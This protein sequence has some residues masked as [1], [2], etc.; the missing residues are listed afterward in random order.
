MASSPQ[1]LQAP[2]MCTLLPACFSCADPHTPCCSEHGL[3]SRCFHFLHLHSGDLIFFLFIVSMVT[4]L[5]CA[6]VPET[7]LR[8]GQLYGCILGIHPII[9]VGVALPS[10]LL[11]ETHL[12]QGVLLCA[13]CCVTGNSLLGMV[14][15]SPVSPSWLRVFICCHSCPGSSSHPSWRGAT[16]GF[17]G[18]W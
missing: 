4:Y 18:F 13:A 11:E 5:T 10:S 2:S 9:A 12:L 14:V 17:W 15:M 16:L 7:A 3:P 6:I 8:H 1:F